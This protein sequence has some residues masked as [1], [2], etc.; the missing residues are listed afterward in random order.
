MNVVACVSALGLA[1]TKCY[2]LI[3]IMYYAQRDWVYWYYRE[4]QDMVYKNNNTLWKCDAANK[5]NINLLSVLQNTFNFIIAGEYDELNAVASRQCMQFLPYMYNV[6]IYTR[7]RVKTMA[8]SVQEIKS[9]TKYVHSE[10]K[11][12][13]K[14]N[15]QKNTWTWHNLP[16]A[17]LILIYFMYSYFILFEFFKL[18][19]NRYVRES[20]FHNCN[21]FWDMKCIYYIKRWI[22]GSLILVVIKQIKNLIMVINVRCTYIYDS[23]RDTYETKDRASPCSQYMIVRVNRNAFL[24]PE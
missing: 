10:E 18:K 21:H 22:I 3:I 7:A 9:D 11:E 20:L 6:Y 2:R 14:K 19:K 15:V 5:M 23:I 8:K 17:N 12:R 1:N 16:L 4:S 24:T 13:I